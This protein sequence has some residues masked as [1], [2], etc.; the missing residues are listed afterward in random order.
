MGKECDMRPGQQTPVCL[1]V[2]IFIVDHAKVCQMRGISPPQHNE[3]L[4]IKA[5][6]QR[7]HNAATEP[8][9]PQNGKKPTTDWQKLSLFPEIQEYTTGHNNMSLMFEYFTPTCPATIPT[10]LCT[11]CRQ[12]HR[13]RNTVHPLCP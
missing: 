12:H 4:N 13:R 11:K 3:Q 7:S 9:Q 8:L 6:H 1:N 2:A 5:L 10:H